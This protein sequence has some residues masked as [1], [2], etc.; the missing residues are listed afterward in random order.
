VDSASPGKG[1][2]RLL[3][4]ALLAALMVLGGPAAAGFGDPTNPDGPANTL[5]AQLTDI[6][7]KLTDAQDRMA[8]AQRQQAA[9]KTQVAAAQKQ[10]QAL[11]ASIG[12]IANAEYRTRGVA[13]LNALLSATS[14]DDFM[15]RATALHE[16][17]RDQNAQLVEYRRVQ[18]D[19]AAKKAALDQQI[20]VAKAQAVKLG[21]QRQAALKILNHASGGPTGVVIAAATAA[22]APRNPDGSFPSQSCTSKDPTNPDGCLTAR[23]LH[24]YQ[25]VRKAGFNHYVHCFRHQSWGEHPKG[26]ACDWA[27]QPG[28][29]GGVATGADRDYGN[30][31]AGWLIGNADRLGVLYVI[32]FRQ[33]WLP[34]VGW[35]AYTTEGGNPSGRHENHVHMSIR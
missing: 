3:L 19:Y 29:F 5:E 18:A 22:P 17:A 12:Q 27:A 20:A 11:V 28:G 16:I 4:A 14:P 8:A 26:R 24:A 21:Q 31:L 30:R 9:L 25:E 1:R 7:R 15:R 35:H 13:T 34:G 6:G 2:Y 10:L 23:T 33:I 32:W